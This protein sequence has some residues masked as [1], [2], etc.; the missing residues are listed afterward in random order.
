MSGEMSCDIV[1]KWGK[2]S[3]EIRQK[4]LFI[5]CWNFF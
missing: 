2:K 3:I 5:Y 4:I 1:F